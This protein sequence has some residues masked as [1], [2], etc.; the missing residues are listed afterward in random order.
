MA[1]PLRVCAFAEQ[2][3]EDIPAGSAKDAWPLPVGPVG[4]GTSWVPPLISSME[5][6]KPN[7]FSSSWAWA[8]AIA[9]GSLVKNWE[10]QLQLVDLHGFS[11]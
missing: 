5:S 11:C 1:V 7:R 4:L 2:L 9:G 8:M 3:G 10:N 6:P